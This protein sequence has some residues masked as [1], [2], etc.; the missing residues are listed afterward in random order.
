MANKDTKT[1]IATRMIVMDIDISTFKLILY[2]K[3]MKMFPIYNTFVKKKCGMKYA[4]FS[5]K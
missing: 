1:V 5:K 4:T 3:P 2:V